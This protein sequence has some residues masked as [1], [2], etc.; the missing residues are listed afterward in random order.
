MKSA[1]G[2]VSAALRLSLAAAATA[3]AS[4]L[5]GGGAE[6]LLIIIDPSNSDS[7]YVGNHYAMK[8][9]VPASNILYL[10]PEAANYAEFVNGNQPGFLGT[11]AG[12]A[13][14]DHIDFVLVTPGQNFFVNA[15]G[16]CTD[17]CFPVNRFSMSSV[18]TM[19][20]ISADILVGGVP[21]T[22]PNR[23]YSTSN[24]SPLAFDSNVT[25]YGGQPNTTDS[26]AR[27][28]FI[29]A[30]IGYSGTMGNTIPE[31]IGLIDKAVAVDGT[32]P[33]GTFYFMNNTADT[34]RNVR[35]G[36]FTGIVN[37]IIANGGQAAK[38]DGL[39]PIGS[40]DIL[41]VMAG[42][43]ET[44]VTGADM[45]IQPGAFCDHLT[46]WAATFDI[47]SQTK[48]TSWIRKGA[49]G[50]AGTVEEP[51]N[52]T[53]KFPH[54]RLH[55][56]YYQGL[57]MG[58]AYLRSMAGIPFQSLLVGDPLCR[59]HAYIPAVT[60]PGLPNSPVSG[61]LV[62][63]PAA[64]TANASAAIASFDLLIDGVLVDSCLPAQQ[65][66]I[67]TTLLSDGWHDVRLLAYDNTLMKTVGRFVDSIVV[68]N[69]GNSAAG[70]ATPG[71]GNLTDLYTFTTSAT[72]DVAQTRLVHNGR[73]IAAAEGEASLAVHG[74]AL[75]AGQVGVHVETLMGDGT[76]VRS[77]PIPVT[78]SNAAGSNTTPPIAFSYTRFVP[79]N[80]TTVVELPATFDADP[81]TST[82][83]VVSGP[84]KS[85]IIAGAGKA[86]RVI[87]PGSA[88]CGTDSI[89][90][91]VT[92][93]NGTSANAAVT[94]VYTNPEKLC[95]ADFNNDGFVNGDDFDAFASA[96]DNAAP[97][98][99]F[100]NDCFVNGDDYDLFANAFEQGC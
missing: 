83:T 51:C 63:S 68:N 9:G 98:A 23:Y 76:L 65:L 73:V 38:L 58:E 32:R 40:H 89:V 27:R 95:D 82:Y 21:S 52:Y 77:A 17:G 79:K 94:I 81:S 25:Y 15:S 10:D 6:N 71:S 43:A 2:I 50:S 62:L 18:F 75:G 16:Y 59:P 69:S 44:S 54:A 74:R 72:G 7:M 13:I 41:G 26:R 55:L 56:F 35:A 30:M 64:T 60:D 11:L 1:R 46:S 42:F 31:I 8:R 80:S 14:S 22:S 19:S 48:T 70:S 99:D 57:S 67:N 87:T 61:V 12:R 53:A 90:F 96:F 85:T 93:P 97:A 5:A 4:A 66:R 100:N 92:T 39:I 28:Y 47:G 24:T 78:I 84:A 20:Q 36:Q 33:T 3:T 49:I 88:A 45:T 34:A 29:G 91:N 37:A 86:Y